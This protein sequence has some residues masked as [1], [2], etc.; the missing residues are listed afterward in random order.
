MEERLNMG[1]KDRDKLHIIRNVLE[2][3]MTQAEAGKALR[4]SERQVRRICARVRA[5]G[6]RSILHGLRGRPSNHRFDPEFL[7]RVLG[8]M[9]DP[10]WDGFGPTFVRDQLEKL[11]DFDLSD[12]TIRDLMMKSGIWA[13]RRHRVKHRAWRE[14]RRCVGMLVQLDGSDHDWFEGRGPRCVLLIYID[15]A[16]SRILYGEFVHVEDTLTLLRSTKA[17]LQQRGRPIAFY[18]DKDSIYKVNRQATVDEELRDEQPMT[19][20]T[21]AMSELG[22][23]VIPANSPQAKGRVE[24]GFCTH[25]DRLVKELRL[26]GISCMKDANRYL[27]DEYIPEHNARYAI[28]PADPVDVHRSLPVGVDLDAVLSLQVSRQVQNDFTVRYRNRFFQ[29]EEDQ[30]VRVCRKARITVR[31]RLDGSIELVSKGQALKSHIIA[32]RPLRPRPARKIA[33]SAPDQLKGPPQQPKILSYGLINAAR[34]A[35]WN[36]PASALLAEMK[37]VPEAKAR[38]LWTSQQR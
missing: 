16:T 6:D 23:E 31:Q 33:P 36:P 37:S 26:R 18:V 17:Y 1:M 28:E 10:G 2:G 7:E 29:V 19:Q 11:Y 5:N 38:G 25:Q 8:A 13:A 32:G 12:Q 27:W 15:D 14:R 24:R 4:R 34:R 30:P 22:I 35:P 9:H 20:F 21:R 3:R